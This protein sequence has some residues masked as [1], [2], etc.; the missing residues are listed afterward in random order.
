MEGGWG[1]VHPIGRSSPPEG[2]SFSRGA[3]TVSACTGTTTSPVPHNP[4][5]ILMRVAHDGWLMSGFLLYFLILILFFNFFGQLFYVY[6][7]LFFCTFYVFMIF[8]V[9][10]SVLE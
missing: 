8:V 6:F 2:A 4:P 5:S 10:F 1:A 9:V 7:Y 3:V